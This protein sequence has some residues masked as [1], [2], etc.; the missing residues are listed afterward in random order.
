M[1]KESMRR[2]DICESCSYLK[3]IKA[4]NMCQNCW[5]K[6]KRRTQPEFFLRTRY[7]EIK[8]R[9]TNKNIHNANIYNG[10]KYCS[11]E[12]FLNKFLYDKKFLKLFKDWQKSGLDNRLCP[13]VD[14]INNNGNYTLSNIQIITHSENCAKDQKTVKV[15]VYTID[16]NFI[17]YFN[18]LNDAVRF[19]KV[20]QSNACKVL[21]NKRKHTQGYIFKYA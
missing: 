7:T 20:Q 2:K 9:C 14:R 17:G 6:V 13:S 4:K 10:K 5:H 12:Q 21:S 18:S 11:L 8:Q 3:P 16:G 15:N 19:T 1:S